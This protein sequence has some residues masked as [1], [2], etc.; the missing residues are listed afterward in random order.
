MK[1]IS[2]FIMLLVS[3]AI[4][5][6]VYSATLGRG[7]VG[8]YV[9]QGTWGNDELD[10]FLGPIG[11][12]GLE[13]RAPVNEN[14]DFEAGFSRGSFNSGAWHD[15]FDGFYSKVKGTSMVIGGQVTYQFSPGERINPFVL[16][17]ISWAKAEW[18]F[19]AN[20][21]SEKIDDDELGFHAGTG[22]EF[23]IGDADTGPEM[24]IKAGPL[25][26]SFGDGNFILYVSFNTWAT[27]QF[28]ISLGLDYGFAEGYRTIY[29]GVRIGF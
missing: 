26:S 22:I 17:G 19:Q 4:A 3:T 5:G 8:G 24:S 10:D 18:T 11:I 7:Y 15:P 23:L 29:G 14:V 9:G 27:E 28:G 13:L 25:Y 1:K 2:L 21:Y 6:N 16:G 20:G 12:F